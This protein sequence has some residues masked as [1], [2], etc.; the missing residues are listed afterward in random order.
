MI[1][2]IQP[3]EIKEAVLW[4]MTDMPASSYQMGTKRDGFVHWKLVFVLDILNIW[5]VWWTE[6]CIWTLWNNLQIPLLKVISLV[7]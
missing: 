7:L 6:K 3:V 1:L 2:R 4:S 5:A